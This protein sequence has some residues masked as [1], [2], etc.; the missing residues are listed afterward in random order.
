MTELPAELEIVSEDHEGVYC[1]GTD[2]C[3]ARALKK[4]GVT[5]RY[6]GGY[7]VVG[8]GRIKDNV[9]DAIV[10]RYEWKEDGIFDASTRYRNGTLVLTEVNDD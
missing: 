3:I 8:C 4:V 9:M 2:C 7:Y 5:V 6:E 1:N 10:G